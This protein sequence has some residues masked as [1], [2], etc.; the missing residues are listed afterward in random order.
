M[1]EGK[2]EANQDSIS[3]SKGNQNIATES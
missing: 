1:K 2:T 3:I